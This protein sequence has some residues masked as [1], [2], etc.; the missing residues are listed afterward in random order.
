MKHY[1]TF[2]YD[3]GRSVKYKAEQIISLLCQVQELE[4]K[5]Q[6]Y[7]SKIEEEEKEFLEFIKDDWNE[8]EINSAKL[9]AGENNKK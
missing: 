5:I 1:G 2:L 6:Y 9:Q 7:K 4:Q 8:E 3:A